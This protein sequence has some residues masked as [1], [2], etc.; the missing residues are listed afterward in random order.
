MDVTAA[1]W[2]IPDATRAKQLVSMNNQDVLNSLI[3]LAEFVDLDSFLIERI[4]AISAGDVACVTPQ[5]YAVHEILRICAEAGDR[6]RAEATVTALIDEVSSRQD[7]TSSSRLLRYGT[8]YESV[9]GDAMREVFAKSF[10]ETY[11]NKYAGREVVMTTP[12]VR[13]KHLT[14]DAISLVLGEIKKTDETLFGEIQVLIKDIIVFDSNGI[15]A[16]TE[17]NTL[18]AIYIRS[19]MPDSEHWSRIAEHIVHEAAHNL[20]YQVWLRE[21]IIDDDEGLFYTPFRQD[22][23]PMSAIFHAMFVLSR[24]IFSFDRLLSNSASG[25]SPWDIKSN[26]NEANNAIPFKEKFFQTVTVIEQSNKATAFGK[27]IL[28]DCVSLVEHSRN[29]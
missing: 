6:A 3:Y 27:K 29:I 9:I 4:S 19:F 7:R 10:A 5:I 25:L 21:P 17:F 13:N 16:A 14:D 15:N 20:L 23:R 24:T 18:G 11:E 26:Y 12:A 22:R 1:N 28:E 2:A 8:G